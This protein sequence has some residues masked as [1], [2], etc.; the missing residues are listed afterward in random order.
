LDPLYLLLIGIPVVVLITWRLL[1][2]AHYGHRREKSAADS[3]KR[4]G[5]AS[6]DAATIPRPPYR[7]MTLSICTNACAA[8]KRI[9]NKSFLVSE[10]PQLPLPNCDRVCHCQFAIHDDRRLKED[11]RMPSEDI[12]QDTTTLDADEIGG[13]RRGKTDRRRKAA[14]YQG[15]Y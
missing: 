12:F 7:A 9:R 10:A 3:L 4:A 14:P 15:I 13:N 6:T 5:S 11:R 1:S 2:S 8:A